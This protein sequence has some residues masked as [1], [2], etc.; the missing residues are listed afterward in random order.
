MLFGKSEMF[1]TAI[2]DV[3]NNDEKVKQSTAE[4]K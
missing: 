4:L 1:K 3:V 2:N